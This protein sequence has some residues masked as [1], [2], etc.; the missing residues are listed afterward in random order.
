LVGAD[1]FC[2]KS[3]VGWWVIIQTNMVKLKI[4]ERVILCAA[5]LVE[6]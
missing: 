6:S 1:L 4:P 2:E 5:E 3:S